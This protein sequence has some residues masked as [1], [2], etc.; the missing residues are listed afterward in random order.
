ME[1]FQL[2]FNN[3]YDGISIFEES[4]DPHIDNRRLADCNEH[5]AEMAGRSRE[6]LLARGHT[7]GLAK[8][9]SEDISDYIVKGV[10][11]RGA[12]SWL[13]PDGKENIIEWTAVPIEMQGKKYTIGID[14]DVTK[15]WLVEKEREKLI[16][17]LKRALADVKMLSGLVPICANCKKIR[18]D[19]GYWTQVEAYIQEHSQAKFSH[20][21]CP[22][23]MKKLYP[24]FMP[25]KNE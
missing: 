23:C 5:Y 15:Q 11:F 14:R 12:F 13:R 2:I 24:N 20:G 9:L 6:E 19:K 3:A 21:V 4:P 16:D 10:P 18:D 7:R 25:K 22:D 8:P 1:K 17:E